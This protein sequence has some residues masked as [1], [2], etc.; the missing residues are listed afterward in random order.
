VPAS[1]CRRLL[2]EEA[3]RGEARVVED[4][5]DT[6]LLEATASDGLRVLSAVQ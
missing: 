6:R 5:G 3:A 1:V 4:A 2:V